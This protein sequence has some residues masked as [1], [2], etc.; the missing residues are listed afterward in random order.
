MKSGR[1]ERGQGGM[2]PEFCE[3]RSDMHDRNHDSPALRQWLALR[4]DEPGQV[5]H[6]FPHA[7]P[8]DQGRGGAAGRPSSFAISSSSMSISDSVGSLAGGGG[9]AGAASG[10]MVAAGMDATD[11]GATGMGAGGMG[12]G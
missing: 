7:P 11:M 6:G 8:I 5:A 4:E 9:G 3:A 1:A 2:A 10:S 12:A